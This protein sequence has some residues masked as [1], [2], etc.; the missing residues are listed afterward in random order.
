RSGEL[1]RR[2]SRRF[3]A[4]QIQKH[5]GTAPSGM[6]VLPATQ[7]PPLPTRGREVRESM[8]AVRLRGSY[9]ARQKAATDPS[10]R[11]PDHLRDDEPRINR[12]APRVRPSGDSISQQPSADR[13]H[14]SETIG[15]D[16]TA[17]DP[18]KPRPLSPQQENVDSSPAPP[19]SNGE[20]EPAIP[21]RIQPY[22]SEPSSQTKEL[23][24]FLQY[25]SKIK[26]YVLPEG[27]S[28]LTLGRLQLAFI[29]K[30]AWNTHNNGADLPEIYIQDPSSGVRHELE[31][32]SDVK[33]RS[34]L[35]LNIEPLDE[36]KRH[37]DEQVKGVKSIL[38]GVQSLIET[39]GSAI[40]QMNNNQQAASKEIAR[41]SVP[42]P[43]GGDNISTNHVSD[44]DGSR[45]AIVSAGPGE[46]DD[47]RS[48]R[49]DL[50]VLRQIY[51]DFTSDISNS[52]KM[53]RKKAEGVKSVAAET[54]TPVYEGDAGRAHIN[55]GKKTLADESEKLVARVDDLQDLVEDLRKDV[56]SRGVRPL[57]RQLEAVG[58][59]IAAVTKELKKMQDFLKKEKP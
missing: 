47:I 20:V 25:K 45:P 50:A 22:S 2:A 30:F 38:E 14:H 32:L 3:S 55:S 33:D 57:P 46:V 36:V 54:T 6:P 49:R 44:I 15:R 29:E 13:L 23:T 27:Y 31:D 16:P 28:G 34:V 59:D 43:R 4:Y 21:A 8:N 19:R 52:M 53:V 11:D 56:V 24:L 39:Q 35:V 26:K 51:T 37:F 41:L 7:P 10:K 17:A 48:L 9:L 12:A 18:R 5:L 40:Q 58:R 42:G 1:E